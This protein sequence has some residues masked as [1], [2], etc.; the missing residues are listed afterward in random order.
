VRAR[1]LVAGIVLAA[2]AAYAPGALAASGPHPG[3]DGCDHTKPPTASVTRSFSKPGTVLKRGEKAE[4]LM[5][6]SCGKLTIQLAQ[7]KQNPIPNAIAFLVTKHFYDGLSI[8]RA[9]PDFVLQGGDPNNNGSGSPG[10]QVVG[11]PPAG[12]HYQLGDVAMAKTSN[13]PNGSSGSQFFLISGSQG[14]VL[15]LQYGVLGHAADKASLATIARLAKFATQSERPS[16][17]LYI[18]SAT[19]VKE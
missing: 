4:I 11:A 13:A 19:L 1:G 15:P 6:T 12:Y 9:V 7:G 2:C 10:F 18:W 14:V 8:F 3:A 5:V 16:K 17:P